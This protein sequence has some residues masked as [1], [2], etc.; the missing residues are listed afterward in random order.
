MSTQQN[1]KHRP[2]EIEI[3]LYQLS[4][5]QEEVQQALSQLGIVEKLAESRS[6]AVRTFRQSSLSFRRL[7]ILDFLTNAQKLTEDGQIIIS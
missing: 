3:L 7:C 4:L 5:T 1:H 2:L 6:L